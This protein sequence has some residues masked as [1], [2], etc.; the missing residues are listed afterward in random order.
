MEE[1]RRFGAVMHVSWWKAIDKSELASA[2]VLAVFGAY[3]AWTAFDWPY[4]TE[5]GPGPGF[6]PLWIGLL[7]L[8]LSA[9]FVVFQVFD[10]AAGKAGA[11]VSWKGSQPAF[12]GWGMLVLAAALFEPAGFVASYLLLSLAL[13]RFIFRRSWRS[14]VVVSVVSTAGFW[15]LFAK[16][17]EVR[18]PTGPWGF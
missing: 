3:V 14:T 10:A 1:V 7:L 5:D 17:L 15:L 18:L 6:F 9:L 8:G 16:L 12:L 11:P 2:L 4:M 13:L